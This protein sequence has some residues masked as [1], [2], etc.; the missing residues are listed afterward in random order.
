MRKTS[1]KT[2]SLSA[3]LDGI[4]ARRPCDHVDLAIREPKCENLPHIFHLKLVMAIELHEEAQGPQIGNRLRY[5]AMNTVD[6]ARSAEFHHGIVSS[7]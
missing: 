6:D 3:S 5:V 1:S 4:C 7:A 2:V